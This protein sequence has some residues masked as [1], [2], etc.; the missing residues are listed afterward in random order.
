MDSLE[1]I[2]H[3]NT[4]KENLEILNEYTERL[5]RL[6]TEKTKEKVKDKVIQEKI[7]KE[8]VEDNI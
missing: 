1:R 6:K 8:V 3:R 5:L 2:S 7:V 4:F